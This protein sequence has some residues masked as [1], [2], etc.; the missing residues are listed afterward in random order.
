MNAFKQASSGAATKAEL[1]QRIA[2]RPKPKVE[3]QL[4]PQGA[5]AV[6]VRRE[7]DHASERR[8]K[9][10]EERLQTARNG[11]ENSHARALQRGRAKQD[12]DRGR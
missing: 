1:D 8:I 2:A 12:F 10:L 3:M 5:E 4:T 7:L 11:L 6:E 9:H